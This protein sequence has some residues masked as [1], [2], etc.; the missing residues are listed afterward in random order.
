[1][2]DFLFGLSTVFRGF[3]VLVSDSKLR[4]WSL[5]PFLVALILGTAI[6]ISG[7][8]FIGGSIGSVAIT[9]GSWLSLNP[10]S[11]GTVAL[12]LALWPIALLALGVAVYVCVR[13]IV[14]PFYS[15]LAELALVVIGLRKDQP[16]RA[17]EWVIFTLRMLSVSI[18]KSLIFAVAAGILFVCSL[19]PVVNLLATIGFVLM[20]SFDV[21]D[22][23]FEAMG[24]GIR[25]RFQHF[26]RHLSMYSGFAF[27]LGMILVIPGMSVVIMPAAVV[28]GSLLLK[29]SIEE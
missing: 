11:W 28:G 3:A 4:M 1:M 10:G 22:Y 13:L 9:L 26:R 14:A 24:W 27:G 20:L 23:S 25:K 8:Y 16:F 19:I 2:N 17:R 7:L 12:T 21:S 29:K 15:I 18:V 5:I 6:T